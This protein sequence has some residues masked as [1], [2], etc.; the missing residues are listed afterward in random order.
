MTPAFSNALIL[1]CAPPFPPEMMA[2]A[3]PI[4]LPGGAVIPAMNDVT[5]LAFGP[6]LCLIKYSAAF[7]SSTP[8][9]SPIKI[10][11]FVSGSFRNTSKQS[12]KFVPLNGSPPIPTHRV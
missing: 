12:M 8:P 10:I 4:R 3:C 6:E 9:I 1:S 7:S 11:P 5:G 2:P